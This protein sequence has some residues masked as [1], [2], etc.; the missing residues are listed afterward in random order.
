VFQYDHSVKKSQV[1]FG[2]L[3]AATKRRQSQIMPPKRQKEGGGA[4][5]LP[6]S[7]EIFG[8]GVCWPDRP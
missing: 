1:G 8:E 2:F 7:Q 6:S 4:N 5:N 3:N